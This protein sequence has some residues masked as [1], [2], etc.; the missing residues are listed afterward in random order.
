MYKYWYYKEILGQLTNAEI[1]MM[2]STLKKLRR[3]PKRELAGKAMSMIYALLGATGLSK[4]EIMT[5]K[6]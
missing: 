4:Y 5:R 6:C 1:K 2:G 3:H